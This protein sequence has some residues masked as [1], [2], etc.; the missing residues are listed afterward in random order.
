MDGNGYRVRGRVDPVRRFVFDESER[1]GRW[2]FKRTGGTWGDPDAVA[3]GLEKEGQI[4]VGVVFDHYNRASIAMHVAV[5]GK[6]IARDFIRV[7]FRYAFGQLRVRKVI[8]LVDSSNAKAL[9]MDRQLGFVT[10]AI[11]RDASPGGD[12][13]IL[14]MTREQCRWLGE[15][16]G[17]QG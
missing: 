4:V 6:W 9:K 5:E 17:V 14:T 3:I 1:V 10:E 8:G 16:H 12:L 2:T 15:V 7:C 13:C 11:I